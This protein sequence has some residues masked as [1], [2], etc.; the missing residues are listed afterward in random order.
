MTGSHEV[1][2][3]IPPG[4]TKNPGHLQV[5]GIF[6]F[7]GWQTYGKQKRPVGLPFQADAVHGARSYSPLSLVDFLTDD[8]MKASR[9]AWRYRIR[10][11]LPLVSLTNRGPLPVRRQRASA[12]CDTASNSATSIGVSIRPKSLF[13]TSR[14]IPYNSLIEERGSST[15]NSSS[16]ATTIDVPT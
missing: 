16:R 13:D 6:R 3:S 5:S 4:S 14:V 11:D 9:S 10:P 1:G 7:E 2:G 12:A 15:A 8:S